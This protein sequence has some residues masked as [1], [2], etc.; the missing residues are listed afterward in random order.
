MSTLRSVGVLYLQLEG[1]GTRRPAAVRIQAAFKK[2]THSGALQAL[3]RLNRGTGIS[4]IVPVS[5]AG[6]KAAVCDLQAVHPGRGQILQAFQ[7]RPT[8]WAA[9][10]F[11]CWFSTYSR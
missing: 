11:L 9:I 7:A 6:G 2:S 8:A 1:C 3:S 10:F 5:S 4:P